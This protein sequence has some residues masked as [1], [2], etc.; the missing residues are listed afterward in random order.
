[1]ITK[2]IRSF[3]SALFMSLAL[4]SSTSRPSHAIIGVATGN[5]PLMIAGGCLLATAAFT[6]T[7][8]MV[9][10]QGR[11]RPANGPV[12]ASDVV[13]WTSFGSALLGVILLPNSSGYGYH[14]DPIRTLEMRDRFH[15][16]NDQARSFNRDRTR[17][18]V[19]VNEI[20]GQLVAHPEFTEDQQVQLSK[21]IW[22]ARLP[23]FAP[24]TRSALQNINAVREAQ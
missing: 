14:Y 16:T 2:E 6:G 3:V 19:V 18:N 5:V 22:A 13:G 1:M 12:M 8:A 21:D 9:V 10:D 15:L 11:F 17:I 4:V 20:Q 24:E 23:G 7:A